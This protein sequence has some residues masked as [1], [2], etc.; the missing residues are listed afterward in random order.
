MKWNKIKLLSNKHNDNKQKGK[1]RKND[2][3]EL[4]LISSSCS[5]SEKAKTH[6]LKN[7][8][9]CILVKSAT[10]WATTTKVLQKHWNIW[11]Y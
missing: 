11:E 9:A 3:D 4:I 6:I 10:I 8:N 5:T 1:R 7:I 2:D